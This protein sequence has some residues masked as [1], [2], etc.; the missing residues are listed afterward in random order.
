[1]GS[2]GSDETQ[3]RRIRKTRK[4]IREALQTL[5]QLKGIEQ[6]TVKELAAEADIGYTTF[7]RHFPTKE[8]AL[9]DFAD[10]EAEDMIRHSLPM[11]RAS[12]S[13]AATTE[14][15]R[16]VAANRRV[17]SA[18]LLGG[19]APLMRERLIHHTLEMSGDWP[20][21]QD[22]LPVESGTTL[23]IGLVVEMLGWWL[24]QMPDMTAEEVARIMDRLFIAQL[25][26][27]R[28]RGQAKA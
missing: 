26:G 14:M 15:C 7:F 9:A 20:Q 10:S 18:L 5:L 6:F 4:A 21:R 28:D 19:A 27:M 13:L 12:D 1:M 25:V 17:W 2:S 24:A 22:W 23:V 16:H 3:D 11:L 8:A